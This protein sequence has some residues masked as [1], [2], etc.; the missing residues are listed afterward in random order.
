MK[1]IWFLVM[2]G[3]SVLCVSAQQTDYIVSG[4]ACDRNV[5]TGIPFVRA[6]LLDAEDSSAVYSC[7][8]DGEG[9]FIFSHVKPGNYLLKVSSMSYKTLCLML[10][11]KNHQMLDTLWMD[12]ASHSL[13]AVTIKE[14]RPIYTV[15]GEKNIY[16]VKED[17]SVQAG[18]M[19][20]ALQQAPGLEVDVEGNVSL[21]GMSNVEIRINDE[22]S[23]MTAITLKQYL[24]SM[25]ASM[26]RQIEVIPNPSARYAA[27]GGGIVNIVTTSP[28]NS[29]EFLSFGTGV[30]SLPY[31][32]PW[33]TYVYAKKDL[34][35]NVFGGFNYYFSDASESGYRHIFTEE[36][37]PYS[38]DSYHFTYGERNCNAFVGFTLAKALDS[39]STLMLYATGFPCK[40]VRDRQTE[41][42]RKE[43]VLLPPE[44]A[45]SENEDASTIGMRGNGGFMYQRRFSGGRRLTGRGGANASTYSLPFERQRFF[46]SLPER[47]VHLRLDAVRRSI[48]SNLSVDYI[49][50]R[51]NKG[52]WDLG[53]SFQYNYQTDLKDYSIKKNTETDFHADTVRSCH[54]DFHTTQAA[55]YTTLQQQVWKLKVKAGLRVECQNLKGLYKQ[56]PSFDFSRDYL[57][58]LPS[59]HLSYQTPKHHHVFTMSYT[60]RCTPPEVAQLTRFITYD[61][62]SFSVGNPELSKTFNHQLEA[63][64]TRYFNKASVGLNAYYRVTREEIGHLSDVVYSDFLGRMVIFTQDVNIGNVR[65]TGGE[66]N[67]TY[68]PKPFLMFRVY[69]RLFDD[70]YS[71][72]FRAGE[73]LDHRMLSGAI[74]ANVWAK[75][76]IFELFASGNF[77]TATQGLLYETASNKSIDCGLSADLFKHRMSVYVNAK[78]IFNWNKMVKTGNNPYY[79]YQ[80]TSDYVSRYLAVGLTFRF[81]KMELERQARK[82]GTLDGNNL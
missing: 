12:M 82:G 61:L 45:F 20:D 10:E 60:R 68:K 1:K 34:S 73:T 24:K 14:K 33:I 4:H 51:Q 65:K 46:E 19:A 52:E 37:L 47:D 42:L 18:T 35:L 3:A 59:L 77:V 43:F 30:A 57:S 74:R 26:V 81:G 70:A 31:V 11:V 6:S 13:K 63:G 50:P 9:Y 72:R 66:L 21:R 62:E 32:L 67:L 29:S 15:D 40:N 2:F 64:W 53:A 16:H 80:S 17:P 49:H 76:K 58:L 79:A 36:K 39:L 78:D 41:Y 71:Y 38:E 23:H 55:L 48:G 25:P 75:W 28:I 44:Y 54:S 56:D 7:M 8:S 5:Q 22:P 69:A 27:S